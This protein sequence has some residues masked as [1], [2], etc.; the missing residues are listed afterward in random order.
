[1]FVKRTSSNVYN[2]IGNALINDTSLNKAKSPGSKVRALIAAVSTELGESY[3]IL[4]SGIAATMLT[5]SSGI[6]LDYLGEIFNVRRM[7]AAS[8]IVKP[9][10][11]IFKFYVLNGSTF[12][13][14]NSGASFTIPKGTA[15]YSLGVNTNQIRFEL[16]DDYIC[17]AGDTELWVGAISD[18]T[19][20]KYNLGAGV[21]RE[22][23][24]TLYT[25]V[26]F[27]SLQITNVSAISSGANCS[28]YW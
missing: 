26:D 4:N 21:I 11:K 3:D 12:G 10:H 27:E 6:F 1:M 22:H 7:R 28:I 17:D 19:G 2:N 8:A 15:I 25:D 13:S 14:I 20:D 9:E 24:F 23:N 18:G 16:D 5:T